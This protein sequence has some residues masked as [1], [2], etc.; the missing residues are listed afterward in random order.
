MILVVLFPNLKERLGLNLRN[1]LP[2]LFFI[3]VSVWIYSNYDGNA[4]LF[5]SCT[6]LMHLFGW[7]VTLSLCIYTSENLFTFYFLVKEII[8]SPSLLSSCVISVFVIVSF[9]SAIHVLRI[10][11]YAG[12]ATYADTII[13]YLLPRWALENS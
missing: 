6:T 11:S 3:L 7:L 2:K 9:S 13:T 8:L 5:L 12:N 10:P 4:V 1:F